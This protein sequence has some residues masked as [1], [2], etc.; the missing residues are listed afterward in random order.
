MKK[1]LIAL[2]VLAVSG[3]ASAQSSVQLYGLIDS[4]FGST[5]A[6]GLKQTVVNSGG[7]QTSRFGFKGSEDLGGGL[8]A[9]FLL[10]SGISVDRGATNT[11]AAGSLFTRQSYVGLSGGFG[12]VKVGK[13]WTA[14]DDQVG[15]G[16]AAWNANVLTPATNVWAS[17]ANYNGNPNNTIYYATPD[18]GG[19]TAAGSY[20]LGENKTAA[21]NAGK[22]VAFNVAYSGG[23]VFV[24]LAYQSE[25][26][27]GLATATKY[28]QIN[29]SYDFGVA[30]LLAAYGNVKDGAD[31]TGTAAPKIKEYQIGV[32]VPVGSA[33]TLSGGYA[34]SKTSGLAANLKASGF[35]V[36][37][38]YALSKRTNLYA[39]FQNAKQEVAGTS[40]KLG[41]YA[42]GIRHTF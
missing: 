15:V 39:G 2:A 7:I 40:S 29:G 17:S 14:Y 13:I 41:T 22:V 26:A 36:T 6:G 11:G 24:G 12:E 20:S 4:Y 21:A 9:N 28:T 5:Y 35:G 37:G 25:K 3:A 27:N 34:T 16:A 32:D 23:P 42:A 8:K 1:S 33:F 30:K 31:V 18:F 10:E 38:L 19:F